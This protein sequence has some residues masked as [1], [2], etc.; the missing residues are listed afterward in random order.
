M[1]YMLI[2]CVALAAC[3]A[4]AITACSH[5]CNARMSRWSH[6]EGCVCVEAKKL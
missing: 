2:L 1:K 5:A 4:D 6:A 3:E